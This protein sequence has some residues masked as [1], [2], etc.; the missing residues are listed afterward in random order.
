[1]ALSPELRALFAGA[2]SK[3]AFVKNALLVSPEMPDPDSIFSILAFREFL[4][5]QRTVW[6]EKISCELY[7]PDALP[8][9]ALY[10]VAQ[11]LCGT[12]EIFM[13]TYPDT[14]PDLCVIFDYGDFARAHIDIARAKDN[15]FFLG[16]DHHPRVPGFPA[17]GLEVIDEEAPSTT[18]LLWKFFRYAK[19]RPNPD[20]ATVLLAGLVADTGKFSNSL[21]NTES[22]EIAGQMMRRGARYAEILDLMQPRMTHAAFIAR[23]IAGNRLWFY[24][25]DLAGFAFLWFSQ[26][27]LEEWHVGEKDIL[28]LMGQMQHIQGVRVAAIYHE[29]ESGVWHCNIRTN[30][31]SKIMAVDIA[32]QLGGGGHA[33]AAAFDSKEWPSTASTQIRHILENG[34]I[35]L[36]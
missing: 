19:F 26:K 21:A 28:P 25:D 29:L 9:N 24:E 6:G 22:F 12:F 7:C 2:M 15:T 13:R 14:I 35:R 23:A 10:E 8:H 18:A 4:H 31:D 20:M 27:D 3:L 30:P 34:H 1:M 16:F 11:P 5:R 33:H 36:R 17:N 32:K